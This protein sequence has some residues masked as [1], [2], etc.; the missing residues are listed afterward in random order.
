[1]TMPMLASR[2]AAGSALAFLPVDF[3]GVH[4]ADH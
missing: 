2:Y 3:V 4:P 1:M